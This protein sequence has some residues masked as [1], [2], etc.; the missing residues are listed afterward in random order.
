MHT[1]QNLP[2]DLRQGFQTLEWSVHN[3]TPCFGETLLIISVFM[4]GFQVLSII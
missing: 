2:P 4:Q 3:H 1:V